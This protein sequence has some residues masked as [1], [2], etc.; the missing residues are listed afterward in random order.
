MT[1][2]T[3]LG[4][5]RTFLQ[6]GFNDARD[7][8]EQSA[9]ATPAVHAPTMS[10]A[11]SEPGPAKKRRRSKKSAQAGV[12]APD[13]IEPKVAEDAIDGTNKIESF[14]EVAAGIVTESKKKSGYAAKK[15]R[16]L[17]EK[18]KAQKG[19]VAFSIL[20]EHPIS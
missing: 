3:D 19:Q 13:G 10:I 7:D 2:Y 9:A 17:K 5:K 15:L 20:D 4:R 18:K 8:D 6:A 16:R 12:S 14:G 11:S 1:R